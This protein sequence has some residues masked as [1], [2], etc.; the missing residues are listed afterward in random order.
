MADQGALPK[1]FL[2]VAK[3]RMG[4]V[5]AHA[6]AEDGSLLATKEITSHR[7]LLRDLGSRMA[8]RVHYP[9]GFEV[10]AVSLPEKHEGL[11]EALRRAAA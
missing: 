1:I 11:Q 8:Y 10:V 6:I 7:F 4:F 3:Q 5:V 9:S 2:Y